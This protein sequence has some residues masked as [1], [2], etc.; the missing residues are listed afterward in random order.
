VAALG[1]PI[2]TI[3]PPT[4]SHVLKEVNTSAKAIYY[5]DRHNRQQVV[6]VVA[7]AIREDLVETPRGGNENWI[8]IADRLFEGNSNP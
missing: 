4:I 1:K 7:L 3:Q 5:Q 8:S 6:D 2:V